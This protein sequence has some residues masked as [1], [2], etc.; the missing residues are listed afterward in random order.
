MKGF[1]L[2]F[3]EFGAVMGISLAWEK[4]L[5]CKFYDNFMCFSESL[6]ECIVHQSCSVFEL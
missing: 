1:E 6:S 2:C 5:D 4:W 3:I